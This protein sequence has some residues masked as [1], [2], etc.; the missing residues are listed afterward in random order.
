VN[1]LLLMMALLISDSYRTEVLFLGDL[2]AERAIVLHDRLI[3]QSGE[4]TIVVGRQPNM[5]VV[6]DTPERLKRFR[7]LLAVLDKPGAGEMHIYVRP[8][9]Y[10]VP[11]ELMA[12]A[13]EVIDAQAAAKVRMVPDDRSQQLLVMCR[14]ATY[15][16]LDKLLR[17]L[18]VPTKNRREIR[19]TPAPTDGE[20]PP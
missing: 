7:A 17:R 1:A 19:V 5:I 2:P 14:P 12:L 8:V 3:G 6:K 13:M 11:S 16:T 4:S 9:Q 15:L 10:V 20:F 18:D